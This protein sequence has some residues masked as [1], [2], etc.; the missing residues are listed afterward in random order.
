MSNQTTYRLEV[1]GKI[2]PADK[3][4]YHLFG[5]ENLTFEQAMAIIEDLHKRPVH[6]QEIHLIQE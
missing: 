1:F 4:A 3:F 6:N 2:E 5:E